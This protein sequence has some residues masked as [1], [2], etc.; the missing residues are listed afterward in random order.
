MNGGLDLEPHNES[1][2]LRWK[3]QDIIDRL[4]SCKIRDEYIEYMVQKAILYT[5]L[6][7]ENEGRLD[8]EELNKLKILVDRIY[9][10]KMW[11]QFWK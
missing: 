2:E 5:L 10:T 6:L 9:P 4:N 11:W 1:K 3:I 8:L 7:I